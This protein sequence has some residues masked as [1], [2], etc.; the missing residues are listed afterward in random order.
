[1]GGGGWWV[2][3][4]CVDGK[5]GMWIWMW[6]LDGNVLLRYYVTLGLL[7]QLVVEVE[8]EVECSQKKIKLI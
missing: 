6:S 2:D 8:V 5:W 3:G 1:M 4:W 7:L